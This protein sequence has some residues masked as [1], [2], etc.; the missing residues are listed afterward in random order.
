MYQGGPNATPTV[1]DGK[2]Y[3]LA[4]DGFA[5]CVD[6]K[7]GKA[8]WQKNVANEVGAK[9]P[10]WGHAGSPTILDNALFLNV[11][12]HG[13]ALEAATGNVI[14]KSGGDAAGYASVIPHIKGKEIQLLVFAADA[15]HAVDPS[16]GEKIWSHPWAT[17]YQVNAADP[18][19]FNNQVFLSTGYN[20]GS[21]V[22]DISG[23]PKVVWQNKEMRNHF[24]AC[25]LIDGRL[26]GFDEGTLKCLD[27][28]TGKTKWQQEGF[29][30]GSLAAC[31]GVLVILSDKGELVIADAK[32]D[33][34]QER[35]RTHV[36]PDKNVWTSPAIAE[37]KI[38]VRNPKG[39]LVA[40]AVK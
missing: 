32:P 28:A 38:F 1:A 29:G 23:S 27:W 30:K 5:A 16:N 40:L 26:Y 19:V 3:I 25:V 21:G 13:L 18:I 12:S 2:V 22:I 11:G 6:A 10:Q 37:G 20:F 39:D 34:Y 9:K 14:W 35:S 17:K 7:T 31:N 36:V 4:K 8:V 15:L 33:S 24:N